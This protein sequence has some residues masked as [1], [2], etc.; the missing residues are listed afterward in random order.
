[1]EGVGRMPRRCAAT[2]SVV[3]SKNNL[4]KTAGYHRDS[5]SP[6]VLIKMPFKSMKPVF[7]R[8]NFFIIYL[9]MFPDLKFS[10]FFTRKV[11]QSKCIIHFQE[12]YHWIRI[13]Q[14]IVHLYRFW[15]NSRFFEKKLSFSP[16]IS[17]AFEKF[18][19]FSRIL[20]QIYQNLVIKNF[21]TQ[22]RPPVFL[23]GQWASKC[24]KT[25][26]IEWM[27]F[28]PSYKYRRKIVI[29]IIFPTVVLQ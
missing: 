19:H 28:L 9:L 21:Q 16:K 10:N 13:L 22:N 29:A 2:T 15:K 27:I 18:Y 6:P 11:S 12:R 23:P 1:M 8:T 4:S 25:H 20:S 17:Y 7:F 3:I 14:Q 5:S 26:H 24:E